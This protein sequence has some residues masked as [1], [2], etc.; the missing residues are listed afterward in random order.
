MGVRMPPRRITVRM[1]DYP[2]PAKENRSLQIKIALP[3]AT[4]SHAISLWVSLTDVSV[5]V[6]CGYLLGLADLMTAGTAG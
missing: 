3:R 4:L 1:K 2:Q 5:C 6:H